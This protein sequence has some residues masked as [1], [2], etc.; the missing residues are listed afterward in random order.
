MNRTQN[1]SPAKQVERSQVEPS[2]RH[3]GRR[4][5]LAKY[6]SSLERMA[7]S[8]ERM[9]RMACSLER[10]ACSLESFPVLVPCGDGTPGQDAWNCRY[11]SQN[12]NHIENLA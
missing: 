5:R 1:L 2:E 9:E 3:Q 10:M 6:G 12:W 7:Y 11:R 8:L 4:F